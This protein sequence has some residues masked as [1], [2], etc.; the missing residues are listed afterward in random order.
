VRGRA[1]RVP[2]TARRSRVTLT[3]NG[4]LAP[5]GVESVIGSRPRTRATMPE[6][7]S[8]ALSATTLAQFVRLES[9]ERY[10]WYR[11]HSRQTQELFREWRLTEQPLNTAAPA[12][13]CGS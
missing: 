2:L 6:P 5:I 7:V 3:V 11:L 12:E 8:Q 9:C 10:L 1:V 4:I 13:G